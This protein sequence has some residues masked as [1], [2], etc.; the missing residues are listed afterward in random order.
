MVS[1]RSTSNAPVI[2]PLWWAALGVS[3][4]FLLYTLA[5]T[6]R[7]SLTFG[8]VGEGLFYGLAGALHFVAPKFY[9]H[10]MPSFVPFPEFV[11][12][13]VGIVEVLLG[14]L[15]LRPGTRPLAARGIFALVIAVYPANINHFLTDR[16]FFTL[17]RLPLQLVLLYWAWIYI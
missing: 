1:A 3:L 12:V 4:S 7:A 14:A 9:L 6:P 11:N 16:S 15:L 2:A 5:T 10:I 17:L 8:L 13:A